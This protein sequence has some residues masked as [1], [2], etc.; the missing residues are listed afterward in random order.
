M[1]I[2]VVQEIIKIVEI[3]PEDKQREILEQAQ[4]LV[5]A[6]IKQTIWQRIRAHAEK[7]PD[8]VWDRMPSDGSENHDHYLYGA[9]KK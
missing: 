4:S 7:I 3:L 1:Q 2:D 8:E 5:K 6:D 9:P